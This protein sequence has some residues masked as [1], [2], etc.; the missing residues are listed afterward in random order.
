MSLKRDGL[1]MHGKVEAYVAAKPM[2]D[3]QV[4]SVRTLALASG[5]VGGFLVAASAQ[6]LLFHKNIDLATMLQRLIPLTQ[7][8]LHVVL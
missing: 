4:P 7:V 2:L 6:V 1:F 3:E 5:V 8:A